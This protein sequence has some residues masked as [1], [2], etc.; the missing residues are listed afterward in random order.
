[1]APK[2]I[3]VTS[4]VGRDLL[5]AASSFKTE[6][7]VVWEYVVNSLQYVD[8]GRSPKVQVTI[9]AKKKTISI[10]KKKRVKGE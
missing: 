4:H 3:N 9:D 8:P 5:D 10:Q 1:M 6:A 2:N 7:A